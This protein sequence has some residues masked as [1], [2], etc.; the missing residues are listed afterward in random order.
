MICDKSHTMNGRHIFFTLVILFSAQSL[1]NAQ[2]LVSAPDIS[3]LYTAKTYFTIVLNAPVVISNSSII[4]DLNNDKVLSLDK[5]V[6]PV[7]LNVASQTWNVTVTGKHPGNAILTVS[8]NPMQ[9]GIVRTDIHVA[10]EKDLRLGLLS[11][12]IGW[13]YFTAWTISFY[14]QIYSNYKKKSVIGLNFDFLGLNLIG[15]TL[16]SLYNLGYYSSSLIQD[17]FFEENGTNAIPVQLNDVFFSIHATIVTLFTI[18][19]CFR[20]ERGTQRVSTG[21]RVLMTGYGLYL[22]SVLGLV[23]FDTFQWIDFL[24]QCSHVKLTITLVKYIPQAYMNFQRKSTSGWSIGNVLLDL[25]GG[26][27]SIMQMVILAINF[28][29]WDGFFIDTTKLGLGLFSVSFDFLF[30]IQHYVLYRN[31]AGVYDLDGNI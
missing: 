5:K 28:D 20:Y 31:S 30:M 21:A 24:N 9:D 27:F 26:T 4:I 6:I 25:V 12:I 17:Q 13:I 18:F 8:L 14:P 23:L 16:Y 29:D 19:Q 11:D 15:F 3:L 2:L 10:V 22:A 1:A 7:S